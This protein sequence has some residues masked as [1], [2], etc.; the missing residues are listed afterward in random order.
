MRIEETDFGFTEIIENAFVE[1]IVCGY[2]G[3]CTVHFYDK[4]AEK[5]KVECSVYNHQ[6]GMPV[7]EDG[8]MLF[9][10][11]WEKGLCAY[12]IVSGKPRW[13]FRPARIRNI[14]LYPKFLIVA[15]ANTSVVKIDIAT[16][17]LLAIIKSGTLEHIFDLGFPYIFA[18]TISGKY[19]VIDIEKMTVAK[20]YTSK[21]IN[22]CECLSL[23]VTNA[24]LQ[25]NAVTISG[26]EQYPQK[27]FDKN[28]R[29]GTSFSR[30]ID[31]NFVKAGDGHLL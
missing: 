14:F 19:C 12:D 18:A 4:P 28:V 26:I 10:G 24:V 7:S 6:Y 13:K 11:S 5:L 3:V 25:Q 2:D 21:I 1:K 30:V 17:E 16:G 29:S 27:L 15:R 9:V 20:T 31:T 8:T 22:P 23:R